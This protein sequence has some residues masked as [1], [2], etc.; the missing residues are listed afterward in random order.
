MKKSSRKLLCLL[1]LLS[2]CSLLYGCGCGKK[3][4]TDPE[5]QQVLKISIA[6]EA[7]PTPDPVEVNPEAVVTNG[8]VTMVNEYLAGQEST[9]SQPRGNSSIS[10]EQTADDQEDI[11]MME[12]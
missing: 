6:P 10:G 11:P 3:K 7:D 4:E 8:N 1:L 12:E 9:G 2:V 5:A